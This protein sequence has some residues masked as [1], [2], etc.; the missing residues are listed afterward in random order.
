MKEF[1]HF[2]FIFLVVD[3]TTQSKKQRITLF[4]KIFA[5]FHMLTQRAS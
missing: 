5:H 3:L 4:V 1:L 2:I